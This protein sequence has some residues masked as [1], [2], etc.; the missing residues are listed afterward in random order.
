MNLK[1]RLQNPS[2]LLAPGVYDALTGLI[3]QKAGAEA[4]YLSGASIA[5]S[6]FGRPDIGLVSMS[7]V[8]DTVAALRDRIDLPIIV[9]ADNG[10][11]NALNVQRTV[12]VF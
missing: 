5:Y 10:F 7:E 1:K 11:G 8:A 9:D 4:V 12:R 3:A 2:I 6:R